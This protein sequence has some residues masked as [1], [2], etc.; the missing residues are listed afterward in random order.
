MITKIDEGQRTQHNSAQL[1]TKA[2]DE[3]GKPPRASEV[4]QSDLDIGGSNWRIDEDSDP[5]ED[6]D[7]PKTMT[8]Q[9][10]IADRRN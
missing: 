7:P 3:A 4:N 2:R 10:R 6:P 5:D 9:E 1:T 8:D